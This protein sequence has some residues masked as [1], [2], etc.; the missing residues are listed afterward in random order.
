MK[1][2]SFVVECVITDDSSQLILVRDPRNGA[3]IKTLD[4]PIELANFLSET[5][6]K[7]KSTESSN[8]N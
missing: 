3:V 6:N 5:I 7:V 1:Q 4:Q 2:F 8:S